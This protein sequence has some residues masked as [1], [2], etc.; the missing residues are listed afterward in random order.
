MIKQIY[1]HRQNNCI[2][3]LCHT[4]KKT[5]SGLITGVNAITKSIKHL[6]ENRRKFLWDGLGEVV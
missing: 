3:T 6:E 4:K 2:P 1:I 5:S